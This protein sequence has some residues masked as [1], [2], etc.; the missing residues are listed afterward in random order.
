MYYVSMSVVT[1]LTTH[2]THSH[3]TIVSLRPKAMLLISLTHVMRLVREND[4]PCVTP[5]QQQQESLYL[6]M[7]IHALVILIASKK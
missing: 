1:F 5:K 3:E 4:S 7:S 6:E 2:S